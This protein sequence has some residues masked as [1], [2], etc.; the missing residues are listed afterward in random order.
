MLAGGAIQLAFQGALI[1]SGNLS[2][3]NWLTALPA[4]FCK[5]KCVWVAFF[6][7]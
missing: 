6:E 4:I 1:I 2:F 3:L 7:E 5:L